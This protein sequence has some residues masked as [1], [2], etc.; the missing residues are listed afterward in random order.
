M[1]TL[2]SH[3]PVAAALVQPLWWTEYQASLLMPLSLAKVAGVDDGSES[4]HSGSPSEPPSSPAASK[5][6]ENSPA[7]SSKGS[8]S[9]SCSTSAS[10]MGLAVDSDFIVSPMS[11][12]GRP[13][14]SLESFGATQLRASFDQVAQ[15]APLEPPSS[16]ATPTA[17]PPPPSYFA[18]LVHERGLPPAPALPPG[19]PLPPMAPPRLPANVPTSPREPI[20]HPTVLGDLPWPKTAPPAAAA[21]WQVGLQ[22]KAPAPLSPCDQ[23]TTLSSTVPSGLTTTPICTPTGSLAPSVMLSSSVM[24]LSDQPLCTSPLSVDGMMS[25]DF[26][27]TGCSSGCSLENEVAIASNLLAMLV[28]GPAVP[29]LPPS[30][31]YGNIFIS[32]AI[33]ESLG[34]AAEAVA[35]AAR[36]LGDKPV[37]VL[38]PW[39]PTNAGTALF[40]HTKPAKVMIH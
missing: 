33:S 22:M 12:N 17:L 37:K 2:A 7:C 4:T 24:Q 3:S 11:A 26:F 10:P 9:T 1:V 20:L 6:P 8:K 29:P 28:S 13:S 38:L 14:L 32:S 34:A 25:S 23:P 36:E 19:V 21:P 40:D 35:A 5:L 15:S 39:Y 31:C 27:S 16:C 18:P 30:G